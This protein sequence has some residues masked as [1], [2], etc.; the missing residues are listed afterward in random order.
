MCRFKKLLHFSERREKDGGLFVDGMGFVMA[1]PPTAK[2]PKAPMALFFDF[3]LLYRSEK[4][5]ILTF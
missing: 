2:E 3:T 5:N 4:R 1:S